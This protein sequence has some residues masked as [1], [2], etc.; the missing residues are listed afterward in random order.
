MTVH[1][2]PF[3]KRL[4]VAHDANQFL[5]E[6][7]LDVLMDLEFPPNAEVDQD[8]GLLI[9]TKDDAEMLSQFLYAFG[10]R[11]PPRADALLVDE[12]W[13]HLQFRLGRIVRVEL[14]RGDTAKLCATF[15]EVEREYGRVVAAGNVAAA[16]RLARTLFGGTQFVGFFA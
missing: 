9:L 7:S 11:L 10:L 8:S 16:R 6:L 12:L 5:A 2:L 13:D 1:N 15:S 14:N 4:V 3:N